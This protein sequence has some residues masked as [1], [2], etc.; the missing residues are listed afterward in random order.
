MPQNESDNS[1]SVK[2]CLENK[3]RKIKSILEE[4]KSILEEKKEKS[5]E[6]IRKKEKSKQWWVKIFNE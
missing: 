4:T 1:E 6:I 5:E 3:E 2:S